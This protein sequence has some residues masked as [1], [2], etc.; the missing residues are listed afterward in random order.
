MYQY[1]K[2]VYKF[3]FYE[4]YVNK[5]NF[6]YV[7]VYLDLIFF[8]SS[9]YLLKVIIFLILYIYKFYIKFVNVNRFCF[10]IL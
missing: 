8:Y 5:E 9:I 3:N 4:D 7:D 10:K 2:N 1:M 6:K